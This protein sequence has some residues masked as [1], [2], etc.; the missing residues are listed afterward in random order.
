MSFKQRAFGLLIATLFLDTFAHA[1]SHTFPS[2]S[3]L[4]QSGTAIIVGDGNARKTGDDTY[5]LDIKVLRALKGHTATTLNLTVKSACPLNTVT[6]TL[7][8]LWFLSQNSDGEYVLSPDNDSRNCPGFDSA[9]EMSNLDIPNDWAV[10]ASSDIK[11]Q[12]AAEVAWSVHQHQGHGPYM[13]IINPAFL[14]DASP[15]VREKLA[16]HLFESTDS[17]EHRIGLISL[18]GSGNQQALAEVMSTMGA[19]SPANGLPRYFLLQ[20]R[21]IPIE[22]GRHASDVSEDPWLGLQ[23][24]RITKA[25][26][27]TVDALASILKKAN[28]HSLQL[29]AATALEN[30]HTSSAAGALRPY[31]N[32]E[33]PNLRYAAIGAVACYANAVPIIDPHAIYGGF[34]LNREGPLK[35]SETALHFVYGKKDIQKREDYY[36]SF[37][38]EW[39]NAHPDAFT[40]S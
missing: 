19:R 40:P 22:H 6:S 9:F 31:L 13:S 5:V 23:L 20:G 33:D 7:T 14:D 21:Q 4:S 15:A 25:D 39:V 24:S 1:Q 35:S 10:A 32:S 3:A 27:A 37:W 11:D 26:A 18:L 28:D 38:K 16:L 29:G 36:L 17:A 30:I 8:S 12:L 34:D 2:L